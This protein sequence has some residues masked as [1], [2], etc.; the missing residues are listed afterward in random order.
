MSQ[1]DY[2]LN[3]EH[4]PLIKALAMLPVLMFVQSDVPDEQRGMDHG[5][6]RAVGY[7]HRVP[8]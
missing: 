6:E 7:G 8:L 1:L 2:D 3:P 5:S 4:P